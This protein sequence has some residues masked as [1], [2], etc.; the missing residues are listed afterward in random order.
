MSKFNLAPSAGGDEALFHCKREFLKWDRIINLTTEP[1]SPVIT[2]F[3]FSPFPVL[4]SQG[5]HHL[6]LL[7]LCTEKQ[8][9]QSLN[10]SIYNQNKISPKPS[11]WTLSGE[12]GRQKYS[13]WWRLKRSMEDSP[14]ELQSSEQTPGLNWAHTWPSLCLKSQQHL[15][16]TRNGERGMSAQNPFKS[17]KGNASFMEF[18]YFSKAFP[19]LLF[20]V[21]T[22]LIKIPSDMPVLRKKSFKILFISG[23]LL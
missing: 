20:T 16:L 23:N 13:K 17:K 15:N 10:Q 5:I 6:Q 7:P 1:P 19:M 2:S 18:D 3:S 4:Q 21:S 14:V 22:W 9:K 11:M 12:E 8:K